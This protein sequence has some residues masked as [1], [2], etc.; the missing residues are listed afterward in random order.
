MRGIIYNT[1]L[2]TLGGE[3]CISWLNWKHLF[4]LE[5]MIHKALL[6]RAH[7]Q[8]KIENRLVQLQKQ[9]GTELTAGK[10]LQFITKWKLGLDYFISDCF[11]K[12]HNLF[13]GSNLLIKTVVMKQKYLFTAG[14][15]Y[16]LC[17]CLLSLFI[18]KGTQFG[19]VYIS[20]RKPLT[21][22]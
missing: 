3:R 20:N 15:L 5:K 22:G 16:F 17:L 12:P 7:T 8:F 2:S 1:P 18:L 9:G 10:S 19:L 14:L 13:N 4:P 11:L 21:G 6:G